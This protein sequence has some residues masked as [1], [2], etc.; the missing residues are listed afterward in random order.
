MR[1]V[2]MLHTGLKRKSGWPA[3]WGGVL[4]AAVVL[5]GIAAP[6]RAADDDAI[7]QRIFRS[8]LEGIGLKKDDGSGIEYRERSPLVVP[9]SRALPPPDTGAAAENNPAWPID[10]EIKRSKQATAVQDTRSDSQIMFD[11]ARPLPPDQLRR[12]ALARSDQKGGASKSEFEGRRPLNPSELGY[13]GGLFK[14]LFGGSKDNEIATF[15][16][17]PARSSLTEPPSGY[18]TPSPNQPYGITTPKEAKPLDVKD[19][20]LQR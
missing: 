11:N 15:T 14:S 19:K 8:I 20:G 17:E 12:G 9:P 6:A 5:A 16:G 3:V 13:S 10:P 4:A 18:Q 1:V 7:D 2:E